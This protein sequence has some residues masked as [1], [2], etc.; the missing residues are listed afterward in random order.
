MPPGS[1]NLNPANRKVGRGEWCPKTAGQ[2]RF[3]LLETPVT[4]HNPSD[5]L[6][7][8]SFG[9]MLTENWR[10]TVVTQMATPLGFH[11]LFS[12]QVLD[13]EITSWPLLLNELTVVRDMRY[14][15][16]EGTKTWGSEV[17]CLNE[18]KHWRLQQVGI[19]QSLAPRTES[20]PAFS[21]PCHTSCSPLNTLP[22][23]CSPL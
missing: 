6:Y 13:G 4:G 11:D 3:Q 10:K 23:F 18:S 15:E 1:H 19:P 14:L 21:F 17:I 2:G 7:D 5:F 20:W 9:I 22:C 16:N 12:H 8:L